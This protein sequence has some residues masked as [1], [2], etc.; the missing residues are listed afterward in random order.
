[1]NIGLFFGTEK[2]ARP[3]RFVP[4]FRR[5]MAAVLGGEAAAR[6]ASVVP[7]VTAVVMCHSSAFT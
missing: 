1:M 6:D 4:E 7:F 5:A 2:N 3:R